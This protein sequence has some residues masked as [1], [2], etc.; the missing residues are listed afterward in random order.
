MTG[1]VR[2]G[3]ESPTSLETGNAPAARRGNGRREL[4]AGTVGAVVES[5]DWTIYAVMA[6]FF[7]SQMFAG[8]SELTKLLAAYAGFAVSFVVRPFGSY[9]LGRLA[10]SRGRRFALMVSMGTICVG[11]LL[12]AALPTAATIGIAAPILLVLLR[13]LQGFAMGGEAP[14]VAAY[15]AETAPEHRRAACP[16][17]A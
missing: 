4:L 5:F 15:I 12:I 16:T 17:A 11:S 3:Q 9:A 8:G 1:T 13:A 6:P 14:S 2:A 7:A 10:D